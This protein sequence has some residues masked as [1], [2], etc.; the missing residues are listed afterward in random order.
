M[1]MLIVSDI[2]LGSDLNRSKDL[3]NVIPSIA[4]DRLIILGDLFDHNKLYRL[5]PEDWEFIEYLN[6][7]SSSKEVIWVEGNHDEQLF[8][9]IP[10]LL[11]I[12]AKKEFE[13][14]H[15]G[16]RFLAIHGHQFDYYYIKKSFLSTVAGKIYRRL[17]KLE[18]RLRTGVFHKI[19]R[20]NRSWIKSAETVSKKAMD[21]ALDKGVDYVFCGHTHRATKLT[22]KKVTYFNTGCWQDRVCHFVIVDNKSIRLNMYVA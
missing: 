18:K 16:K 19:S 21:Y 4:F 15:H 14:V 3:L 1:K 5:R 8:N 22:K 2:H 10:P 12:K 20:N 11:G 7:L 6:F 13:W 17:L 9:V